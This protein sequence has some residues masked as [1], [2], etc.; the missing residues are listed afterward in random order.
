M[1][2]FSSLQVGDNASAGRHHCLDVRFVVKKSSFI[3]SKLN[4]R[5]AIITDVERYHLRVFGGM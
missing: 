1:C 2:I 5:V 3:V 4:L